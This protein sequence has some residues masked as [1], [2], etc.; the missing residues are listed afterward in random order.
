MLSKLL[1][2]SDTDKFYCADID[3][4]WDTTHNIH[5]VKTI[6]QQRSGQLND[7]DWIGHIVL[8]ADPDIHLDHLLTELVGADLA[9]RNPFLLF[10]SINRV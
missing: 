5:E 4:I 1:I 2:L 9:P 10:L 6:C 3:S 7:R 8:L